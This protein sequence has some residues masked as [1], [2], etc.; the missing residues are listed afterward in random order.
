MEKNNTTNSEDI[1]DTVIN[2]IVDTFKF[3]GVKITNMEIKPNG[4]PTFT[5]S[6][7]KEKRYRTLEDTLTFV[8]W[9]LW[10]LIYGEYSE[11]KSDLII[12]LDYIEI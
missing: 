6:I 5:I 9:S 4:V 2:Q 1:L 10:V 8:Y 11:E 12:E 3:H 7:S